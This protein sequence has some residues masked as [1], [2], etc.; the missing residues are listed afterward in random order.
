MYSIAYRAVAD[1]LQLVGGRM[2]TVKL[3]LSFTG[4]ELAGNK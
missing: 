1:E 2:V 3:L 4:T